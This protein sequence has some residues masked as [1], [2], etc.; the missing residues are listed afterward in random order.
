MIAN[1]KGRR[2]S[3]LWVEERYGEDVSPAVRSYMDAQMLLA[4]GTALTSEGEAMATHTPAGGAEHQ[5]FIQAGPDG[6]LLDSKEGFF[7]WYPPQTNAANR[8]VAELFNADATKVVRVRGIWLVPTLTSVTG[9]QHIFE[10]NK[11]SA[12]GTTSS[13]T[14]T[15]RPLDS[16]FAALDADI[17][18]R[19]GSTAGATLDFLFFTIYIWNEETAAGGT[20][21]LVAYQNQLPS[22]GRDTVELVLRQNQGVQIKELESGTEAGLTGALIYFVVE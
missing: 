8:E 19:Y 3:G 11:I 7:V 15:P 20:I 18:A 12:V 17:T 21:G 1:C 9:I 14:V 13:T 4:S 2:R 16:S 5:V 6:H 22:L 10:V